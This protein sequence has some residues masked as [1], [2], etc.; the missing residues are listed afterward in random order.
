MKLTQIAST[1]LLTSLSLTHAQSMAHD[2]TLNTV[3]NLPEILKL[4]V[5][6]GMKKQESKQDNVKHL[7]QE[8]A[9]NSK[10]R[11]SLEVP[12]GSLTIT[13]CDCTQASISVVIKDKPFND[14]KSN[15]S[16]QARE[17]ASLKIEQSTHQVNLSVDI[18]HTD[19]DFQEW[20][21]QLPKYTELSLEMGVG[22]VTLNDWQNTIQAEVGVGEVIIELANSNYGNIELVSGVGNTELKGIKGKVEQ[23]SHFVGNSTEY[24]GTG[25]HRLE[26]EVGVGN[27]TVSY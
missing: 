20:Q 10:Q 15:H 8:F 3:K 4:V 6:E 16:H 17:Q 18:E 23:K 12:I 1:I 11:L 13:S 7:E 9:L 26:V 27:I 14:G 24:R 2:N 21:L 22:A 19:Q 25:D 5:S